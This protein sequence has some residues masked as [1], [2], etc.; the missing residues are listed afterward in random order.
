MCLLGRAEFGLL[1]LL[2]LRGQSCNVSEKGLERRRGR[3]V[4][5]FAR[6]KG[7]AEKGLERNKVFTEV[8]DC[9]IQF[10]IF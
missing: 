8:Q 2:G 9:W 6:E 1:G 4:L 5:V 7:C 10:F 3:E